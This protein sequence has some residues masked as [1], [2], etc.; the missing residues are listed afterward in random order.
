M[1]LLDG[2]ANFCASQSVRQNFS[3]STAALN[4]LLYQWL[5]KPANTFRSGAA[6]KGL[7][8]NYLLGGFAAV[9]HRVLRKS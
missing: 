8:G 2:Q 4:A 3:I 9:F 1:L 7:N 6:V 5:D